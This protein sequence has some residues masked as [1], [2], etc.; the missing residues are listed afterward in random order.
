MCAGT[1]PLRTEPVSVSRV[2]LALLPSTLLAMLLATLYSSA[3]PAQAL[4]ED[5]LNYYLNFR[6]WSFDWR[7]LFIEELGRVS[8]ASINILPI[9]LYTTLSVLAFPAFVY[10]NQAII[11]ALYYLV[12]FSQRRNTWLW[13][14]V[15]A[16]S[17]ACM[18][19]TAY[20]WR[21][22]LATILCIGVLMAMRSRWALVPIGLFSVF[23]HGIGAIFLPIALLDRSPG[24]TPKLSWVDRLVIAAGMVVAWLL[25]ELSSSGATTWI[26]TDDFSLSPTTAGWAV[27]FVMQWWIARSAERR[28][29]AL[30][31]VSNRYIAVFFL[32]AVAMNQDPVMISR[33]QATLTLWLAV[34]VIRTGDERDVRRSALLGAAGL[35]AAY[36]KIYAGGNF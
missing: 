2:A 18:I 15:S 12:A 24:R 36:A 13:V 9:Y 1:A 29:E 35:M 30:V 32:A 19:F 31:H 6:T 17:P 14:A 25:N 22:A 16:L 7:D 21:Q 26:F 27:L 33:L 23:V 28:P 34:N 10:W 5:V 11:L 4:E 3:M 20:V 8:L